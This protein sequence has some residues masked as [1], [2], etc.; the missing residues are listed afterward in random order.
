[1]RPK[2]III[3]FV[4]LSVMV[5]MSTR[6]ADAFAGR[7]TG[8][9]GGQRYEL[10]LEFVGSGRYEG[11]LRSDGKPALVLARRFGERL[12]GRV[13][14]EKDGVALIAEIRGMGISLSLEGGVPI[15]LR[16]R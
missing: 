7:F 8:D 6:A 9:H 12:V 3:F 14:D 10:E 1:M 11:A 4:V 5:P 16:R 15:F 13:G 2:C